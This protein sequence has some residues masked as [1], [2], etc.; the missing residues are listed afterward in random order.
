M[1]DALGKLLLLV[2][3]LTPAPIL[4]DASQGE[5]GGYS[6]G[7]RYRFNADTM[8][9]QAADGSLKVTAQ[10]P[11]K[12]NDIQTVYLYTAPASHVIG[13]IVYHS[14]FATLDEARGLATSYQQILE[15]LYPGWEHMPA[16]VPMGK[17]GGEMLSRLHQ[18]PYALIVFYRSTE[19]GAEMGVELEYESSS[20]MRK[21]W[22]AELQQETRAP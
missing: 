13:K 9:Q 11:S 17:G 6:L 18:G 7:E 4:A 10:A 19:P 1:P 15:D 22:K 3:C 5:M 16:P 14:E 12:P 20:P 21:A 2:V 8:F